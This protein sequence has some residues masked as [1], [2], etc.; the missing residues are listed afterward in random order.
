M[1]LGVHVATCICMHV[2][3]WADTCVDMCADM[4]ADMRAG[5]C[6]DICRPAR[7]FGSRA[8]MATE[9]DGL[10]LPFKSVTH[11]FAHGLCAYLYA[12]LRVQRGALSLD[13]APL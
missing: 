1:Y 11:V 2:D 13:C 12:C 7:R 3:M 10:D 8:S 5:M 6:A 4:C 9:P